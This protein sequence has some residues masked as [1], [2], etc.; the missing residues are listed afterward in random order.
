MNDK[1]LE[2]N[3]RED[4]GEWA[5]GLA[6]RLNETY[7]IDIDSDVHFVAEDGRVM[8]GGASFK[9]TAAEIEDM[10]RRMLDLARQLRMIKR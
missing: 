9:K 7:G 8:I 10:A 3:R 5:R 2:R 6:R 1:E 4:K